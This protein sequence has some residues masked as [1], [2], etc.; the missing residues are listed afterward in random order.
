MK[1]LFAIVLVYILGVLCIFSLA[2]RANEVDQSNNL[3]QNTYQI[4]TYSNN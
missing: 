3:V 2:R 4:S 1:N